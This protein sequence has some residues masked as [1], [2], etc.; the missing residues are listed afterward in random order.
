MSPLIQSLTRQIL[1]ENLKEEVKTTF[2]TMA[3]KDYN[4]FD[5]WVNSLGDNAT[6]VLARAKY[7]VITGRSTWD[8]NNVRTERSMLHL[9]DTHS[10]SVAC[11]ACHYSLY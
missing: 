8:G 1:L 4:D 10:L 9:Q 6:V 11:L 5:L 3:D 7:P 2:A